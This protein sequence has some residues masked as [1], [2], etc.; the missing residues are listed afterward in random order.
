[1]AMKHTQKRFGAVALA[2][3]LLLGLAAPAFAADVTLS[4]TAMTSTSYKHYTVTRTTTSP[5]I[6]F[7]PT[8]AEADGSLLHQVSTQYSLSLKL[9]EHVGGNWEDLTSTQTWTN[10]RT[11]K[12]IVS[13]L[14]TGKQFRVSACCRNS[15]SSD[16]WWQGLL[17]Y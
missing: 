11:V 7:D 17:K 3:G 4:D 5:T 12:T 10:V 14:A 6:T 9:R 16:T 15:T 1:M 2:G 8:S 13:G